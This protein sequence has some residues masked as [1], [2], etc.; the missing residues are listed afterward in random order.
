MTHSS[1]LATVLLS[2]AGM[3]AVGAEPIT[4]GSRLE[5][6]VDDYLIQEM[7]GAE[8]VLHHPTPREVAIVHDE[9]WEGNISTYVTVFQDGDLYRMYYRGADLEVVEGKFKT[10]HTEF[11]CYAESTDGIHWSKPE[12]GLVKFGGSKQNNIML[13]YG[14]N[15]TPFKDTNPA[16]KPEEQYKALSGVGPPLG[17]KSPDGIHWS[18]L[19][20]GPVITGPAPFDSQNLVFWDTVRGCYMAYTRGIQHGVRAIRTATSPDFRQWTDLRFLIYPSAPVA[21][22]VAEHL[23]TNTIQPYHRAPHFYMGFPMRFT[24]KRQSWYYE[25]YKVELGVSDVVF[26][27][28][29]DGITFRRWGEAFIRPGP[30]KHRWVAR[31]NMV[32]CGMLVTK[33]DRPG[34]PD[35]LSLYSVE[36]YINLS[37]DIDCQLRRY[38]IRM[39]GFVSLNAPLTGGEVVT[40]PLSFDG[41]QLVI[42][43]ATSAAGSIR[44]ELQ[45]AEGKAIPGFALNDCPEIF[46]D[47]IERVVRWEG[48]SDVSELAGTPVRLRLLLKDADLYSIRFRP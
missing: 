14:H 11:V 33:S 41:K 39:D 24:P 36:G 1:L 10:T 17:F 7:S 48:G 13:P 44:V 22:P 27:A 35:E 16:C 30:Q 45:D 6:F 5:L 20:E 32:A 19:G 21:H 26:M 43:F 34:A 8:L 46:G 18:R 37:P 23:Y 4:I 9:P 3:L 47:A 25:K 12:L 38:T 42:N 2:V 29:R 15:F 31:D 28:S 40:R